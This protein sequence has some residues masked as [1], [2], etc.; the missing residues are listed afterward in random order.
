MKYSAKT[1][2]VDMLKTQPNIKIAEI[3]EAKNLW[4]WKHAGAKTQIHV[5]ILE[6]AVDWNRQCLNTV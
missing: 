1:V 5:N 3:Q 4:L 6:T 2:Y